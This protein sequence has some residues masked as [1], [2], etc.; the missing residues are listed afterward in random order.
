MN[1]INK[2]PQGRINST[3]KPLTGGKAPG[4]APKV[5]ARSHYNEPILLE[6]KR[7]HGRSRNWGDAEQSVRLAAMNEIIQQ[8]TKAGL[9][10]AETAFALAVARVESGFN[11]DAASR[12]S[13]AAGIGQFIDATAKAFGISS[14]QRFDLAA[15]VKAMIAYLKQTLQEA[16]QAIPFGNSEQI[17]SHAYG[18]YHDGPSLQSGGTEI[19]KTQ[20]IPFIPSF[21][22]LTSPSGRLSL[23]PP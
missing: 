2:V 15:N 12:V 6:G 11:P 22:Q 20:V 10:K 16:R 8:S 3:T 19:G 1:P 21:M 17:F 7:V 13:S 18:L 14:K 9:D 5:S 4:A 23:T